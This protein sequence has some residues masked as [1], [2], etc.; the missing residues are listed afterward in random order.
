MGLS[1]TILGRKFMIDP[2]ASFQKNFTTPHDMALC[3]RSLYQG[4]YLDRART[5]LAVDVM[6]RQQYREKIPL[7]LPETTRIAHKTGEIHGVRH[8][9]ALILTDRPYLLVCL[10]HEVQDVLAADRAIAELSR[11]VYA[12]AMSIS[13]SSS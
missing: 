11:D 7:L 9:V 10:T 2:E 8:D 12:Q 5:D 13:S 6:A 1:G 4:R 3:L